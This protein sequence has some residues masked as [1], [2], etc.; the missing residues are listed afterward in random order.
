MHLVGS[1]AVACASARPAPA[2]IFRDV[3][4]ALVMHADTSA[5]QLEMAAEGGGWMVR[6]DAILEDLHGGDY[7]L[8]VWVWVR[9][10]FR[11]W[12]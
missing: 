12:V 4:A 9:H 10:D 3:A 2:W 8:G 11:R 7:F 5:T 1:L 6:Q